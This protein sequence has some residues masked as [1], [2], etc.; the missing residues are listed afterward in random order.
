[1]WEDSGPPLN[2]G[3]SLQGS[4]GLIQ[5]KDGPG[6]CGGIQ[7]HPNRGPVLS[8]RPMSG[9]AVPHPE[10]V[11]QGRQKGRQRFP[12]DSHAG[13]HNKDGLSSETNSNVSDPNVDRLSL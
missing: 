9:G 13:A 1:M 5:A 8:G 3:G 11:Q 4:G 2:N 6:E 10:V 12:R 7:T